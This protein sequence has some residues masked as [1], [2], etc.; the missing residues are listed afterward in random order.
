VLLLAA[1]VGVPS[2]GDTSAEIDEDRLE[3][4]RAALEK[5]VETRRIIS[6]ERRDWVLG[7]ELLTD[8]IELVQREVDSLRTKVGDAEGSI[9]EADKQRAELLAEN[10]RLKDAS[11]ALRTA[12]V[13][14]EDR[15]KQLLK[16]LPDPIRERVKPLSQ[17]IPEDPQETKQSLSERFQNLVGVLNEVNKFNREITL[18]SEVRTL[19]DGSSAE[20]TS[21]YVGIGHA[22]YVNGTGDV[23]G[24]GTATSDG[25]TWTPA[26][27]SAA[28]IAAA[29]AILKNERPADFVPLPVEID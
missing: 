11:A 7:K 28:D 26:N 20:V 13:T 4:T 24:V 5:W 21:L 23:A 2:S 9:A 25:W 22:Y 12:V 29:I 10:E 18:T 27:A 19:P 16:R 8:R 6:G 1:A 14:L 3:N 15:T 17:R